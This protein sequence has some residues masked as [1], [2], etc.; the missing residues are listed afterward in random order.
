MGKQSGGGLT[1]ACPGFGLSFCCRIVRF[2]RR[3]LRKQWQY[4]LSLNGRHIETYL[5]TYFSPNTHLLGE[6]LA[7]F[8]LGTL[9]P[10]YEE[11]AHWQRRGWEILQAE[12]AKQVRKDGFY[13]EQS[14]YYHVYALDIFLHARILAG[15]NG[16]E[17]S[18]AFDRILQSMLNALLLL[19]RAG[20]APS[21]GD[22]DGGRIFDPMRN[23][24]EHMLDPLATG[25]VLYRRGDFK[26]AAGECAGRNA[27]AVGHQGPGG[28][29]IYCP[30]Q[31]RPSVRQRLQ[32]AVFT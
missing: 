21:I 12:A 6:A 22:D 11:A 8:F 30:L 26:F 19:E 2:S 7:L 16:V 32:R 24:A 14:T 20:I 4:A 15:L 10:R 1:G 23:R 5:S 17:I 25:A 13:F 18:P 9:I 27:L 3:E 31:N 28:V 29:S